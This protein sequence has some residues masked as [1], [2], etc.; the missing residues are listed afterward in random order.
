MLNNASDNPKDDKI[1]LLKNLRLIPKTAKVVRPIYYN[2]VHSDGY[3]ECEVIGC[4]NDIVAEISIRGTRH[5]V[6]IDYLREMQ[7]TQAI[8]KQLEGVSDE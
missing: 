5:F 6:A 7:P 4:V 3:V 2:G 8:R 1:S